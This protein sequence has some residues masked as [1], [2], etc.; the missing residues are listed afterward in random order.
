MQIFLD[1]L[2]ELAPPPPPINRNDLD[3]DGGNVGGG[4]KLS[5]YFE[6]MRN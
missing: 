1:N 2:I 5:K 3:N 4:G 6:E